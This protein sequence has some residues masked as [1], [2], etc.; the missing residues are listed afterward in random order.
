MPLLHLVRH[1]HAAAGWGEDPD[2]GLD[3][4]G[5]GQ[6]RMVAARLAVALDP[7]ALR[8]SPLARARQTAEPLADAWATEAVVDPAFGEI[9]SPTT[10]LAARSRWLR[11]ALASRWDDL[12]DD[13]LAWRRRLL[14]AVRSTAVDTVVF[15]HFVAINAVV[16]E[17][18]MDPATTVFLPAN[19]SVTVVEVSPTPTPA[20]PPELT[21]F[22]PA[23]G[24]PPE[25]VRVRVVS[26]GQ[27]AA[28]EVG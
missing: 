4:R 6:A 28:P 19:T 1:G 11:S 14:E 23:D 13:V 18:T 26:L 3:D 17:A 10:D 25:S 27:E 9:P 7:C 16:G 24:E 12:G 8:T 20:T 15:T 21:P 5:R 22:V 2:P